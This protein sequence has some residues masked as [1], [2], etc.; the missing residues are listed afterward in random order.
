MC[1]TSMEKITKQYW[2]VYSKIWING[3]V[4]HVPGLED[5]IK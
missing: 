4:Q 2:R 5:S 1:N 3:E